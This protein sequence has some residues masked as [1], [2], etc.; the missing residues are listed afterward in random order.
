MADLYA[1]GKKATDETTEEAIKKLKAKKNYIPSS[2]SVRREYACATPDK[3]NTSRI[4]PAAPNSINVLII[5]W[6]YSWKYP[7]AP[8]FQ[9]GELSPFGK[10]RS[11]GIWSYPF[12]SIWRGVS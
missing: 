7:P 2:Y 9:R 12:L 5:V 8:L 10:G 3:Y 4:D 11:G 6:I 1:K